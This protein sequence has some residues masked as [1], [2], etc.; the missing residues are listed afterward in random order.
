[1]YARFIDDSSLV[2]GQKLTWKVAT[3]YW[4]DGHI[5]TEKG[6]DKSA[7]W[8]ILRVESPILLYSEN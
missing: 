8:K 3:L 6:Q 4:T 5:L 2:E 7:Q 1:M